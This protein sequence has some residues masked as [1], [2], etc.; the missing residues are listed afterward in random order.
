M[1]SNRPKEDAMQTGAPTTSNRVVFR[2][3]ENARKHLD[4]EDVLAVFRGQTRVSPVMFP[5]VG[6]ILGVSVAKPRSVIVTKTSLVTVQTSL[7]SQSRVV[8][9]VSRHRCG[10]VPV[11]LTR[12]GLKIDDEDAIF[13]LL[14]T[15]PAMK[16]VARLAQEPTPGSPKYA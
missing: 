10:S 1:D 7:W 11:N 13:A 6:S 15:F 2:L 8:R 5:L 16:Q 4:G 14:S 3:V 9:L 12:W